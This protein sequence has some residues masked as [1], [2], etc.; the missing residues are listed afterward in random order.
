[1]RGF[2]PSSQPLGLAVGSYGPG[3]GFA[4]FDIRNSTAAVGWQAET[5]P[6][7]S[8]EN[9]YG[10]ARN[11][12]INNVDPFGLAC[13]SSAF[14]FDALL[15]ALQFGGLLGAGIG[16]FYEYG[17]VLGFGAVEWT[18]ASTGTVILGTAVGGLVAITV[19]VYVPQL[20]Q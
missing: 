19:F 18:T 12:P 14:S 11:D 13:Q 4:A 8:Q 20:F 9:P 15:H 16:T 6:L 3:N 2:Q 7:V 1:M 17:Y 10:Y 5:I